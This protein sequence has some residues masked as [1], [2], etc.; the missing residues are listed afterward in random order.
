MCN[1][2][3][4]DVKKSSYAKKKIHNNRGNV[5]PTVKC[6]NCEYQTNISTGLASHLC[7]KFQAER[8]D[9]KSDLSDLKPY[10]RKRTSVRKRTSAMLQCQYC[11]YKTIYSS[12]LKNHLRIHTDDMVKQRLNRV[13]QRLV[14][15]RL[16]RLSAL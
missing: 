11:S 6:P 14:K 13:K 12:S 5:E 7:V 10:L 8:L 9:R 4:A 16:K 1:V 3:R 2:S 15:Q